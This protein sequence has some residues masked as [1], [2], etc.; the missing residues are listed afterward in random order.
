MVTRVGALYDEL[1]IRKG[2][3]IFLQPV[4]FL[5]RRLVMAATIVHLKHF[6][7]A[8][9]YLIFFQSAL[10]V[11]I[12][13]YIRAYQK[14][15]RHRMEIFN[16]IILVLTLYTIMC[17]SDWL[18]DVE[19]KM[20]IGY[21]ACAL[22]SFHFILNIAIMTTTTIQVSKRKCRFKSLQRKYKKEREARNKMMEET[23]AKRSAKRR[24]RFAMYLRQE[25]Q[26][27]MQEFEESSSEELEV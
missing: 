2:A 20:K 17:F 10:S 21:V 5:I 4:F 25:K 26:A 24:A 8:Q 18:S 16:E 14:G 11:I 6:L 12:L 3:K 27:K 9:I 15:S 19:L 22:V 7:A 1:D 23:R 13:S